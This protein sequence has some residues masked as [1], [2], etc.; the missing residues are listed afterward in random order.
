MKAYEYIAEVSPEGH[1]SIP[2]DLKDK[3]SGTAKV[4][5]MLLFENDAEDP[6]DRIARSEFL[7][8]YS[9][10]DSVYDGL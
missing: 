7:K 5:V 3:L 6:W 1:I 2:D 8:G 4:R 10:K 9:E